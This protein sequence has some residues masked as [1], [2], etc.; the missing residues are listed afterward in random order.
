MDEY[1]MHSSAG[2]T[3]ARGQPQESF[4]G[5][6]RI[7][8]RVVVGAACGTIVGLEYD[9]NVSMQLTADCER[10]L[11]R[12]VKGLS[13]S[14]PTG[15]Y[16]VAA[17]SDFEWDREVVKL[18]SGDTGLIL[19]GRYEFADVHMPCRWISDCCSSD[20]I[21]YLNSCRAPSE[22]ELQVIQT[23]L[24]EVESLRS[25]EFEGCLRSAGVRAGCEEQADGSQ[26]CF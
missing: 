19:E 16:N 17:S 3:G 6:R 14:K 7:D 22:S 23:C 12:T 4:S 21:I 25:K 8:R 26:I 1:S 20:G 10:L 24:S 13:Q 2:G 9:E 18:V 11:L 15:T 5:A